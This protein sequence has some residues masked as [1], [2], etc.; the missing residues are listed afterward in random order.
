M[1]TLSGRFWAGP[2]Y[3]IRLD[4]GII[5]DTRVKYWIGHPDMNGNHSWTKNA[6]LYT[7]GWVELNSKNTKLVW[8]GGALEFFIYASNFVEKDNK[9]QAKVQD[10]MVEI[11]TNFQKDT[12]DVARLKM[13]YDIDTG[14]FDGDGVSDSYGNI[15]GSTGLY[16]YYNSTN[17]GKYIGEAGNTITVSPNSPFQ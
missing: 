11:S 4:K 6:K 16:A 9:W 17:N 1:I 14:F 3:H 15:D 12:F 10:I 7:G 13:H 5:N 2:G 8:G